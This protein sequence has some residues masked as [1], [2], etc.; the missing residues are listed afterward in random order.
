MEEFQWLY[1]GRKGGAER[2]EGDGRG[3][4]NGERKKHAEVKARELTQIRGRGKTKTSLIFYSGK[5][6]SGQNSKETREN[7]IPKKAQ[8]GQTHRVLFPAKRIYPVEK[9]QNL[10]FAGREPLLAAREGKEKKTK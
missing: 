1:D 7:M 9:K 8:S 10:F 4:L 6:A 3:R 5:T 2:R